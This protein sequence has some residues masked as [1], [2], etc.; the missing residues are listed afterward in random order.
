AVGLVLGLVSASFAGLARRD[1]LAQGRAGL[2]LGPE[3]GL[4]ERRQDLGVGRERHGL[5]VAHLV[6]ED[7]Q[8]AAAR[9]RRGLL[10]DRPGGGVAG[11]GERPLARRLPLPPEVLELPPPPQR[12]SPP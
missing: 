8:A 7:V 4:P 5:G 1:G 6:D 3:A 11:G 2:A 10:A 9:D 12:R